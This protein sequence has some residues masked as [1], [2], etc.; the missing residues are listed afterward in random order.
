MRPSILSCLI[1]IALASG[2]FASPESG[3]PGSPPVPAASA[4]LPERLGDTGLFAPGT[5]TARSSVLAYA[6]RYPLWSDGAT[7]RRWLSL[8]PGTSIDASS[9]DAWNFPVG[10]RLWKEFGFDAPVETRMIERT[11]DGEWRFAVYVWEA[12]G[13]DAVLAPAPGIPRL[14]VAAAPGGRYDIPS[15]DDC[16]SCHE[17][18]AVPVLGVSAVQLAHDCDAGTVHTGWL[19]E[20]E[21]DLRSLVQRGLVS[22]LPDS[23][24]KNSP[25]IAAP[26]ATAR[27]AL[28]Y[29]HANCGHCHNDSGSLDELDLVL[30]QTVAPGIDSVQKVLDS[31]VGRPSE[32][33]TRDLETRLVPGHP[34]SSL[35]TARMRS[36]NPVLQMPPLGTRIVDTEGLAL[37]ER[38][39]Q[40]EL[41]SREELKQ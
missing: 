34:E 24:L 17:G 3:S 33:R 31:L 27:S 30:A 39:I 23:V 20:S 7:K 5:L 40:Q 1:A 32:F 14:P 38:W 15:Q 21:I 29:L 8:P 18:A 9:P 35:L 36:R 28:G 11:A 4:P 2:A 6:P 41:T 37:V 19:C 25:E 13:E 22:D 26:S 16:R 12:S 10:T